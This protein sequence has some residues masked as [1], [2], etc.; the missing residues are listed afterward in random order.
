[1]LTLS[2]P[3]D[4]EGVVCPPW[5]L[6]LEQVLPLKLGVPVLLS[7]KLVGMLTWVLLPSWEAPLW[8]ALQLGATEPKPS[9]S[10][11]EWAPAVFGELLPFGGS[12]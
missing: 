4:Q 5:Q 10:C 1:M 11:A 12:P 9:R 2:V 3:V 6:V 8:Q 7:S